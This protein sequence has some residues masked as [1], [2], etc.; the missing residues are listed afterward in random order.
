MA[1]VRDVLAAAIR[2]EREAAQLNEHA[3]DKADNPIARATLEALAAATADEL[4]EQKMPD[5]IDLRISDFLKPSEIAPSATLQEILVFAAKREHESWQTYLRLA[6]E[7]HDPD[8][9]SLLERL[10]AQEKAYKLRVEKLYD[11]VAL[12]E[13]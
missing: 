11:N 1:T 13:N 9:K 2:K 12:R 4:I 10:A 8:A 5:V 3:R 6:G 7:T